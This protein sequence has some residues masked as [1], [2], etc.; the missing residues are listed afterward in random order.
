[1]LN[2]KK[3]AHSRSRHFNL[4]NICML[5]H[6][7][8]VEKRLF[9]CLNQKLNSSLCSFFEIYYLFQYLLLTE[10]MFL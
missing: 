9:L 8:I 10:T 6:D 3:I 4:F 2:A 5:H 7:N 1:M